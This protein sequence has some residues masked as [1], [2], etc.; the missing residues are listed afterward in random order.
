[1]SDPY[2]PSPTWTSAWDFGIK[3]QQSR[4]AGRSIAIVDPNNGNIL[5]PTPERRAYYTAPTQQQRMVSAGH[6]GWFDV[7]VR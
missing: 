1:L 2:S 6:A 3:S 5:N 4:V 7:T